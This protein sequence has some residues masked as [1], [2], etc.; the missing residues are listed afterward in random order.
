VQD[1]I[2]Q[3]FT[4][5]CTGRKEDRADFARLQPQ[6]KIGQRRADSP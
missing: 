6:C 5:S 1:L 2:F 3:R 4:A